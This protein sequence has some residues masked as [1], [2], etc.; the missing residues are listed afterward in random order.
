ML[1]SWVCSHTQFKRDSQILI[2]TDMHTYMSTALDTPVDS[3][4]QS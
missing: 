4:D 1:G 2:Y 3:I